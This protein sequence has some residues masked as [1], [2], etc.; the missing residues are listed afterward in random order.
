MRL[1]P[2]L[3][4]LF[5]LL[6]SSA[7]FG[8]TPQCEIVPG[9]RIGSVNI[10][11]SPSAVRKK[12]GKPASSDKE[13]AYTYESFGSSKKGNVIGVIY[14]NGKVLQI[15]TIYPLFQTKQGIQRDS[16]WPLV[17]KNYPNLKVFSIG[18][19]K[20]DPEHV[21]NHYVSKSEGI[22]FLLD[23]SGWPPVTDKDT[24]VFAITVFRKGSGPVISVG[25]SHRKLQ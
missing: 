18:P 4:L 19:K 12:I 5:T 14:Q 6:S 16:S 7:I 23:N 8:V 11:D 20:E 13:G 22:S 15:S 25:R 3:L 9:Q 10:G 1:K 17:K 21:F 2:A 24:S